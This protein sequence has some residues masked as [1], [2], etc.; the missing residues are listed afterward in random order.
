MKLTELL[1]SQYLKQGDVEGDVTVTVKA[2]KKENVARKDEDPEYKFVIYF[3]EYPKGMVLNATNIKR[4][5]KALGEDTDDWIGNAVIL[6]VDPDVEFG[7]EVKG[8]LRI[9]RLPTPGG[10]ARPA[11]VDDV[12]RKLAAAADDA[13]IPF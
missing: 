6:Y 5:G 11:G 1:Q 10:K 9:K 7:G 4:L 2:V 8:G 13:E 12:N 3:H